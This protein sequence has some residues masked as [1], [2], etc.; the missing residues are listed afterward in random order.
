[1]DL[2]RAGM[3]GWSARHVRCTPLSRQEITFI[4][5]LSLLG[6]FCLDISKRK[7][8]RAVGN[9]EKSRRFLRDFSKSLWESPLF[10]DFHRDGIFHR[11]LTVNGGLKGDQ[12]QRDRR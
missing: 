12:F 9:V 5:V 2:A 6:F 4:K 7:A 1:V 3:E 10:A 8:S 11:P